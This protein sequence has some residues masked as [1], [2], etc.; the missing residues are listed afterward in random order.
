MIK[1]LTLTQKQDWNFYIDNAF[2]HDWYHTWYYHALD[3]T[4]MALLFVYEEDHDYIAFPVMKRKIPGTCF[5]DLSS[6]YGY[7][8]PI[9]SRESKRL[10]KNLIHNFKKEFLNFLKNEQIVSVFSRLNPF[11][12]QDILVRDFKGTYDNGKT[13]VLDLT[14]PIEEQHKKYNS[15]V[16]DSIKKSRKKGFVVKET[17]LAADIETFIDIY[18]ENMERV[19][20]A[21]YYLFSRKYFLDLMYSDEFDC[22]LF[23]VFKGTEAIS[24]MIAAFTHGIIQAHLIGT[25]TAYINDSPAKLLVDEVTR[26]GRTERMKYMHLGGGFGFKEDSLF[27]WKSLFSDSYLNYKSLRFI[28]NDEVYRSLVD[29]KGID[30]DANVDFFPLYR[31]VMNMLSYSCFHW[32]I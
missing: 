9:A 23:L 13:V 31:A 12:N 27:K 30:R 29:Q 18:T 32:I 25:R 2:V 17:K 20:S 15:S 6:V 28:A 19:N 24:G 1:I 5:F 14:I 3:E 7:V 4:G 16:F 26:I 10:N 21:D 11:F 22:R 8:G